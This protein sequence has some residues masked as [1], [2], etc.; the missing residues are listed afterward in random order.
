MKIF[1]WGDGGAP[2]GFSTVNTEI[3]KGLP[4]DAEVHHLAINYNGDPIDIE[5]K[6][7]YKMYPAQARGNIMGY[8]RIEEFANKG[9]DVIYLLNDIW[10]LD[11]VLEILKNT[12]KNL[13]PIVVY[14]PVDAEGYT[15]LWFKHFDIVTIPVVYTE[16]GKKVAQEVVPDINFKIINHGTN[17]NNFY[18]MDK[19]EAK[20]RKYKDL[21]ELWDSF[22]VLNANRNQLRKRLDLA[23]EGFALFAK[24]KPKNVLYY[25][26]AGLRDVGWHMPTLFNR[27]GIED[28]V[29]LTNTETNNQRVSIE[30]LNLIYNATDV[31]INTSLGEGWGLTNTEHAVTGAPQIVPNHSACAE[32]FHDCG[33]LIPTIGNHTYENTMTIGKLISPKGLAEQLNKIYYEEG[34]QEN[35]GYKGRMKFTQYEYSWEYVAEEFYM[36]FEK[37]I[38]IHPEKKFK[39]SKNKNNWRKEKDV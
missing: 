23:L 31:G 19:Q 39:E 38:K 2:T 5:T 7:T 6:C 16:F 11:Q 25:H 26:H 15:K 22:I 21:P 18:Q 36:T 28:R 29:I 17:F 30:H 9:F 1:I 13:P 32:L 20:Q 37:A 14:F 8:N 24:D 3:V 12:W 34:L 33:L 10:V 27:F 35:L 4:E